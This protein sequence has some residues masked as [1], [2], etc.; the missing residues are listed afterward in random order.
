M[1]KKIIFFYVLILT[2]LTFGQSRLDVVGIDIEDR[3]TLP[4]SC[5]IKEIVI[6]RKLIS[7]NLE[8]LKNQATDSTLQYQGNCY[9]ITYYDNRDTL[10]LKKGKFPDYLRANIYKVNPIQLNELSR[11]VKINSKTRDSLILNRK[12]NKDFEFVGGFQIAKFNLKSKSGYISNNVGATGSSLSIFVQLN[13]VVKSKINSNLYYRYG[14]GAS[15]EYLGFYPLV[16]LR[17]AQI[18]DIDSIRIGEIA[19]WEY[20]IHFPVS[21]SYEFPNIIKKGFGLKLYFG[22]EN[23]FRFYRVNTDNQM[24]ANYNF[25]DNFGLTYKNEEISQIVN[26]KYSEFIRPYSLQLN[27]GIGIVPPELGSG[28]IKFTNI[29][30]PTFG[31]GQKINQ[32]LGVTFFVEIPI[33]NKKSK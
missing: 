9:I 2:N 18:S 21:I 25:T 17:E 6:K 20:Q 26:K 19:N 31:N 29:I 24:V 7:K 10:Y 4:D 16:T 3:L 22:L 30:I 15:R 23:R 13:K 32:Q 14:V 11:I 27:F 33:F 5:F 8:Q 1:T 12:T 28:G